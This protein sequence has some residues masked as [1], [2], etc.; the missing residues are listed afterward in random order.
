MG[1]QSLG[2]FVAFTAVD[3]IFVEA[4]SVIEAFGLLK[5]FFDKLH[6]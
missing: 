5:G 2:I 6:T 3:L 4:E 1:Q